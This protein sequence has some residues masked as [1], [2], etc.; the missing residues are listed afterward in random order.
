MHFTKK[1][2]SMNQIPIIIIVLYIT[3]IFIVAYIY[4]KKE[5]IQE[6]IINGKNT[7]LWLM[8]GGNI[9]SFIG[10]SAIISVVSEVYNTGIGFGIIAFGSCTTGTLLLALLAPKIKEIGDK[11]KICTIPD[12][13]GKVYDKKNKILVQILQIILIVV[14]IAIQAVAFAQIASIFLN[15]EFQLAIFA[16]GILTIVY[17]TMG[18]LKIDLITDFVQMW[19][20]GLL[21]IILAGSTYLNIGGISNLLANLPQSHFTPSTYGAPATVIIISILS[22]LLYVT[23]TYNWQ[24]IISAKNKKVAQRSFFIA[25]PVVLIVSLVAVFI[26]LSASTY[27]TDVGSTDT[28]LFLL[29]KDLLN[30]VL[31]GIGIA[32]I[33]A[34]IMSSLDT[35][36]IAGSTIIYE[37]YLKSNSYSKSAKISDARFIT[38]ILGCFGFLTGFMIPS[39]VKLSIFQVYFSLIFIFPIFT[40][41]YSKKISSDASFYSILLGFITLICL[42]PFIGMNTIVIHLPVTLIVLLSY[43]FVAKLFGKKKKSK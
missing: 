40:G 42:Y 6:Y 23:G 14:W 11:Y 29:M 19:I 28:V 35:P 26:G 13:F 41:L 39:I 18:G 5:T 8:T 31:L 10:A 37:S 34:V 27:I 9:A 4:S 24:R 38:A 1:M 7:N 16:S 20:I 17:V 2:L 15:I 22:G 32:A 43:D 12:F 25:L 3:L 33:I 21:I 30:P 36:L